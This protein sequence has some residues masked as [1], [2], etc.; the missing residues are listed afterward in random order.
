MNRFKLVELLTPL[1]YARVA[2]FARIVEEM[3]DEEAEQQV[4]NQAK[5]FEKEK[6]YFLERWKL[7]DEKIHSE[8]PC[9]QNL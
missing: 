7:A 4:E 1:Y 8:D 6:E 2:S 3:S 9:G 5:C